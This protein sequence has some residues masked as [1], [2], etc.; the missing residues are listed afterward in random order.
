MTYILPGMNDEQVLDIVRAWV[1]VLSQEDYETVY[2]ELGYL[3]GDVECSAETIR[4][5]IKDYRSPDYYPGEN[6]FTVTDWRTAQGGNPEPDQEVVWYVPGQQLVGAV[7]FDLPLNG[8]W[9]DLTAHFVF[10]ENAQS[11]EGHILFLEEIRSWQQ[12][13]REFED[14]EQ[15]AAE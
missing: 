3:I 11:D 4:Q 5:A 7:S 15:G 6:T 8:R 12:S 10:F 13:Q 2:D 9:S 1:D 14:W